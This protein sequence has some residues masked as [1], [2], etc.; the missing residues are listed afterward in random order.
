MVI[1]YELAGW[2]CQRRVEWEER[3]KDYNNILRVSKRADIIHT[4]P[5]EGCPGPH[6]AIYTKE[7]SGDG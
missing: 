7:E 4:D 6:V 3:H 2:W 5:V 1:S